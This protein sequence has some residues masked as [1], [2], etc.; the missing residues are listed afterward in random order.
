MKTYSYFVAN[1]GYKGMLY[2]ENNQKIIS[3]RIQKLDEKLK[4]DK[5][6]AVEEFWDE[7]RENGSPIIEKIEGDD[8]NYLVTVVWKECEPVDR[9]AVF[10]E[11]FG[12]DSENTQLE[13]LEG[14][15]LWHR[16]W[17][18]RGDA[19]SLYMFI[20]NEK[21]GQ[22]W[23]DFDFR[24]D[25]FNPN[26]YVCIDDEK[27]P[28]SYYL[29][30]KEE[31]YVSLPDFKEKSWTIEKEDVP[32]GKV[33][34]IEDFESKILNNK[35]RIWV[36]T[37]SGY[38]KDSEPMGL[39]IFTDGWEYVH[40]TK[41]ITTFDNLIAE[42]K[43]PAMCAVFIESND[44]RDKELTCSEKFTQFVMNE[45]LPWV[46]TNYNI[47]NDE[48][49]NLISGFSYGGLIAAFIA[50]KYPEVFP[51]VLCQSGGMY[52]K[53]KGDD[54]EKGLI[55]RMYENGVKQPLDFYMTFGEFEKESK[56]H[57]KAN[58]DFAKILIDK[59]YSIEY[60]EFNGGHT[61]T[62]L[63]IELGNGI[64]YLLGKE[65]YVKFHIYQK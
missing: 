39:A 45:L 26:K 7:V 44:D 50:F 22:E 29:L 42:G 61:Y 21:E 5:Y 40:V 46:K 35:R 31:S 47:K 2:M 14:T 32:R 9:M 59:G 11:M 8:K 63:D 28:D 65:E 20:V 3:P 25:P 12:M 51:K 1:I 30:C 52:W 53:E 60:R 24:M 56:R 43:I 64:L 48:S 23:D 36:Y 54:N 13:K 27:N 58:K 34:L 33:E 17:K 16:T 4:I 62:D 41:V 19:Q 38:N 55:L 49:K 6:K 57:Y 15:D 10:G 37:P 18:V